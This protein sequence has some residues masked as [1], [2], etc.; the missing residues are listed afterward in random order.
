LPERFEMVYTAPD[1]TKRRPVMIHRA[2]LGSMERF[3]GGL[4]EHVAGAFPVW[5][6]PVQARVITVTEAH[7]EYG[8]SV[9][10]RLEKAGLRAEL[11]ARNETVGAKIREAQ[12]E[13]VPYS[14]VVGDKEVATGE[15][16]VRKYRQKAT[17]TCSVE[18]L[19]ARL[20]R[21]AESREPLVAGE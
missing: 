8:R 21:E 18:D 7:A 5:L 10:E 17:E 1:G 2:L 12:V 4:I 19:V 6:A 16:A 13:K 3:I 11:D 14:L 15:V 9:V 20:C